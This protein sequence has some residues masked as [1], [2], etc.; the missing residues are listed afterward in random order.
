VSDE[1]FKIMDN[2][3]NG[4][5]DPEMKKAELKKN[6]ELK[7]NWITANN[8]A[9]KHIKSLSQVLQAGEDF[10]K[11][12]LGATLRARPEG[13]IGNI[14]KILERARLLL[15]DLNNLT[16]EAGNL[17]PGSNPQEENTKEI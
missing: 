16:T 10:H 14:K 15:E 12:M 9:D 2:I 4:I 11:T 8:A 7:T 1:Y 13:S 5:I 3:A 6:Q 17:I